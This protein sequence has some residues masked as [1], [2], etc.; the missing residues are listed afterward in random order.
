M[1]KKLLILILIIS[2]LTTACHKFETEIEQ[3]VGEDIKNFALKMEESFNDDEAFEKN[4][5]WAIQVKSF[6]SVP[7]L[8]GINNYLKS[9]GKD[10]GVS[11][12]IYETGDKG[13]LKIGDNYYNYLEKELLKD[14]ID[15][16]N[17]GVKNRSF[18]E[19]P[20]LLTGGDDVSDYREDRLPI[21]RLIEKD[22]IFE[23]DSKYAIDDSTLIDGRCYGFGNFA[24]KGPIG[25][26]WYDNIVDEEKALEL[27]PNPWDN[28]DLLVKY[29]ETFGLSPIILAHDY[30]YFIEEYKVYLDFLV[31][32]P[33]N[34]AVNYVFDTPEYEKMAESVAN[35]RK[36]SLL[37]DPE[38]FQQLQIDYSPSVESCFL[39]DTEIID[40]LNDNLYKVKFRGKQGYFV[41]YSYPYQIRNYMN[42]EN[43]ISQNSKY[44]KEALDFLN[45]MYNDEKI[46]NI[47]YEDNREFNVNRY[48]NEWLIEDK[49][50]I[51][52]DYGE[53]EDYLNYYNKDS[54]KGFNFDDT[55]NEMQ[56]TI[57]IT[58][59]HII[60][61]DAEGKIV[62]LKDYESYGFMNEGYKEAT[63][64]L[65]NILQES[66]VDDAKDYFQKEI[67]KF[68]E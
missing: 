6:D 65:R 60:K 33:E 56:Y 39:M 46:I 54:L 53:M 32:N 26:I 66:G 25:F 44:K 27:D 38:E 43:G 51:L 30:S 37:M 67:N 18:F 62:Y 5:K 58:L 34:G 13:D 9:I 42:L 40:K 48:C 24:F 4:L 52:Y 11:F 36:N 3:K 16:I 12:V 68:I 41:K 63:Q 23:V 45:L 35:L 19:Y 49:S 55:V 8:K 57:P 50:K 14:D 15:I 31:A 64:N 2:F 22:F 28:M 1:K 21:N 59:K 20:S 17:F 7:S 29:R 61:K 10:Y 47:F